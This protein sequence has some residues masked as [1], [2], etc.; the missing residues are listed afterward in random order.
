L[1]CGAGGCTK[2]Y[3][4]AGFYVV[5]VD[6]EPQPNYCGDD[7]IRADALEYVEK[8]Y[9]LW[10]GYFDAIHAS[11]PCQGYSVA[12]N[13]HGRDDHPLLIAEVRELLRASGL[14]YVIENV[15]GAR[16]DMESPYTL[17]G[18]SF[19]LG[20]KRHRCF[21]TSFP[22]MVPPCPPGHPGDWVSVFGHTVLERGHVVGKAKGGGNTIKRRH[23]GTD[24]GREAMG[25]D[26]MNRDELSESVPPA[27][28]EHIGHYLLAHVQQERIAA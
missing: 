23:L 9:G 20:V 14:A 24:R 18:L 17:C 16:K 12:N 15:E 8:R 28:T 11:P 5:G 10:A 25:I 26:W 2:G 22:M 1:F 6:I 21:E 4:R 13:I 27:Y 3:Q 19:G 7:F